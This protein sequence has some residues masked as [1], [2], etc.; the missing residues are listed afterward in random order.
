M[1]P[2]TILTVG[3]AL[4]GG[5]NNLLGASEEQRKNRERADKARQILEQG[6]IGEGELN[7]M[8]N[9]T[10]RL[11]NSRLTST[12]NSTALRSRGIANAN[13]VSGAVAGA[14]EADKLR[15]LSEQRLQ[16]QRN[17]LDIRN[18]E[19]QIEAQV[20]VTNTAGAFVSGALGGAQMGMSVAN[21]AG[22]LEALDNLK[23]LGTQTSFPTDQTL[24]PSVQNTV[25]NNYPSAEFLNENPSALKTILNTDLGTTPSTKQTQDNAMPSW[26]QYINQPS[27]YN[28]FTAYK[29]QLFMLQ[30]RGRSY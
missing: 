22:T 16:V 13:V 8:L 1:D 17:N 15:S 21:L 9:N 3:G 24:N 27:N 23:T 28:P 7:L 30:N 29:K 12:L 2:M 5:I 14:M 26:L 25:A 19:A 6:L 4:F 18:K 20:P 10:E 11:F